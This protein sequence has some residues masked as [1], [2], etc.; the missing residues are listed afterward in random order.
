VRTLGTALA[1]GAAIGGFLARAV[2]APASSLLAHALSPDLGQ[3][4]TRF[5]GQVRPL[6]KLPV[7]VIAIDVGR[8]MAQIHLPASVVTNMWEFEQVRAVENNLVN[9]VAGN[10][11]EAMI[12]AQQFAQAAIVVGIPA[13]PMGE[14][15][16][17]GIER[18]KGMVEFGGAGGIVL[19]LFL[20]RRWN[21]KRVRTCEHCKNAR[22]LLGDAAEDQHLNTAQMTEESVGSVD[23]DVWWCGRCDDVLVL[24]YG[25]IFSSYSS[26]PEC[27]AR[28]KTSS[29][30]TIT[31]ATEYS[32]GLQQIDESCANCSYR[33]SYTRTTARIQRSSS[34]SSSWSSSRSSSSSSSFG[35]GR[36]SGGG[37]S[38][39]W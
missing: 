4:V 12:K 2:A 1:L 11:I 23:Y 25:A 22:Q 39:S 14:A 9:G 15:I 33:N 20:F 36:S 6:S 13:R 27:N 19:G 31:R 17:R 30:T 37:S 16:A 28:T 38:G 5:V 26:C 32:G 8:N 29:T 3:L 7:A 10:R 35:G 24:R 34:S 18:N 21:R